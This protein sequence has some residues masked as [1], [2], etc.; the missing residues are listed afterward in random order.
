MPVSFNFSLTPHKSTPMISCVYQCESAFLSLS[1][2]FP[3]QKGTLKSTQ[4]TPADVD[5]LIRLPPGAFVLARPSSHR[6]GGWKNHPLKPHSK[7]SLLV[8]LVGHFHWFQL[9]TLL[10]APNADA[11]SETPRLI[12]LGTTFVFLT[13]ASSA[14]VSLRDPHPQLSTGAISHC[15]GDFFPNS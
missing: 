3:Q 1:A 11:G 2:N 9:G 5:C 14:L 13:W 4:I 6:H 12:N 7:E 8:S 10:P 15:T